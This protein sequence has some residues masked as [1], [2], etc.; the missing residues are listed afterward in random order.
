MELVQ[1]VHERL[2]PATAMIYQITLDEVERKL[3]T[4]K[5]GSSG[6]SSELTPFSP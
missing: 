4:N 2:G 1:E 5:E 6:I 3:K